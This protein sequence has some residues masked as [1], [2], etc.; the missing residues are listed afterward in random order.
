MATSC[1][2]GCKPEGLFVSRPSA[3]PERVP[4]LTEIRVGAQALLPIVCAGIDRKIVCYRIPERILDYRRVEK[5][6]SK[7]AKDVFKHLIQRGFGP[8]EIIKY[9]GYADLI[10]KANHNA[11]LCWSSTSDFARA[12]ERQDRLT[13]RR[14]GRYGEPFLEVVW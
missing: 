3:H 7:E 12:I 6:Y 11:K 8:D 14:Y 4:T 2:R 1:P 9:P 10:E 13:L 5:M